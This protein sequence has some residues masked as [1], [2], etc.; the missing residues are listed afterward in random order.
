MNP[1]IGRPEG[2]MSAGLILHGW[3]EGGAKGTERTKR[4]EETKVDL[5]SGEVPTQ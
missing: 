2:A 4:M 1:E 3:D 5:N